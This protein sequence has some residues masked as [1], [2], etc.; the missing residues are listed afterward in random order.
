M[1]TIS[2]LSVLVLFACLQSIV[3]SGELAENL[4]DQISAKQSGDLVP[5]WI[6]L[7][8]VE[9]ASQFKASV[10]A[11]ATT[12][13]GRYQVVVNRFRQDHTKA[14][15]AMVQKLKELKRNNLAS[16]IKPHWITN[17]VEVEVAAG[18]LPQLAGR[19]DVETIYAVPRIELIAPNKIGETPALS[20]GVGNDLTYINADDAWIAGYTGAGRVICS[21]DTGIEGDHPAFYNNWKGHDGDSAAAWFDP[22]DQESFPHIISG[23]STNHGTQ[24]MG[25]L[26]GH[27]NATGDTIGVAPDAKWISAAV[28]DIPGTSI[29]DAFEWAA[30]PDG[31]PNS[32]DDVPDVI[33]HSWGVKD[34]GCTNIFYDLID[35]LEALGIVNIFAAGN[36]GPSA[37]TIRNPANRANDSLDCFAVGNISSSSTPPLISSGSSRGPSDCNGA[38]KPNVTAPGVSIRTSIP[39]GS[40]G[41]F[42]GTSAATP[43]V[44]GLVALLRQKNPNATVDEIKEAI[45]TTAIDYGDTGPDND[46]GWGV[47]D[48]MAAL[49]A[50]SSTNVDANVRVYA[51][52][53]APIAPGN[54]VE[55]TVVL[56][57]LGAD[58]SGVSASL[59]GSDLSLTV[60]NGSAYFGNINEGDT[61]RSSDIIRV[62]VSDTITEGSVL[63]LDFAITGDGGYSQSAKLYFVV[64]PVSKHLF[65]THD[66]GRIEFTISNFGTYGLGPN[67]FF[68]AGGVGFCFDGGAND[69]YEAGLLIGANSSHVSD[70]V[71][72]A[73]GEPDGDY[74]VMPGGNIELIEPG[75]LATQETFSRFSD[76]RAE[77][78]LGLEITQQS[79]AFDLAPYD[80]FLIIRYILK[81]S[82]AYAI[83][84]IYVSLYLDWD[85]VAFNVNAGGWEASDSIAWMAYN[86]GTSLSSFRGVRVVDGTTATAMTSKASDLVSYP[87]GFTEQEKY[88]SLID[89]FGSASTY[90]DALQDLVQLVSAG[91]LAIDAGQVDTVAFAL[92]GDSS[93][94]DIKAAAY[95]AQFMYDNISTDVHDGD[96]ALPKQFTLSQNYP[97]P[98]NPS[99]AIEY[100][101]PVRCHVELTIYNVLGQKVRTLVDEI[102]RACCQTVAW[103]GKNDHGKELAS[104][105]YL[106][107]IKAGEFTQSRKMLL[108]K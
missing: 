107:R 93:L 83:S 102:Q 27:D 34:I 95:W 64:E 21:F 15:K 98:F 50:L 76:A 55:G 36:E 75:S 46:Y 68:P 60:L 49:N 38:I 30:D 54:T 53:H 28:I 100:S 82:N 81:N 4:R 19:S 31:D 67:S 51:F 37:S 92:L 7:P 80:D 89:G 26:V 65:A 101:L 17:I 2:R 43:H 104:G 6:K 77:E 12:R 88:N 70:G 58:V 41:Y 57:N 48:C 42:S 29:I 84:G 45:L 14:Q 61:V 11:Q 69:L 91:P 9:S 66:A 78:P 8:R 35:N 16:T 47:V 44:S 106:Y 103:D 23:V 97:N 72:N 94:I 10:N 74:R 13:A 87:E 32:I 39:G 18:E 1:R 108:L 96:G 22:L 52:D 105:I 40:Y 86:N 5:V 85:V 71:R 99:T 56:Q 59:T 33:N 63:S 90:A 73:A 79:Y 62:I 24:T 20:T 3:W 25:I